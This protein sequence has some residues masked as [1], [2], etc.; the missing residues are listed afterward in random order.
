MPCL[1]SRRLPYWF[2]TVS[3][4]HPGV[5]RLCPSI[6]KNLCLPFPHLSLPETEYS[7]P[8]FPPPRLSD[9][10]C[11]LF[12]TAAKISCNAD[13]SCCYASTCLHHG[14]LSLP[15]PL[16]SVSFVHNSKIG[17]R[18][19]HSATADISNVAFIFLLIQLIYLFSYFIRTR[20]NVNFPIN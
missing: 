12:H 10:C 5:T 2:W 3:S 17:R 18:S 15:P 7:S 1:P 9:S 6:T 11:R 19:T 8:T 16:Y 14:S 13:L 20:K 4:A